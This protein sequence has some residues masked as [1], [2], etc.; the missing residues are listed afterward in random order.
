MKENSEKE[1]NIILIEE[2]PRTGT[3]SFTVGVATH[4]FGATVPWRTPPRPSSSCG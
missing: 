3:I 4:A 2:V 1:P